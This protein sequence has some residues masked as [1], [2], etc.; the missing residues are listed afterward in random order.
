MVEDTDMQ[1]KDADMQ[2]DI[3]AEDTQ[4]QVAALMAA[5]R[6]HQVMVAAQ[7]VAKTVQCIHHTRSPLTRHQH[8]C[9]YMY[10]YVC[11]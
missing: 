5:A 1:E 8:G 10:I 4:E 2:E 7:N 6:L 11:A 9:F 3:Q